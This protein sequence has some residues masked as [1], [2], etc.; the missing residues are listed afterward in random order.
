MLPATE[1]PISVAWMNA[2]ARATTCPPWNT[3]RSRWMSIVCV[4][5]ASPENGSLLMTTSPGC[6]RCSPISSASPRT[7]WHTEEVTPERIG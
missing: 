6:R 2:Q 1:P 4:H 5:S 7:F 3:G